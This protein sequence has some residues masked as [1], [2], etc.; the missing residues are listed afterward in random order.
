VKLADPEKPD[1]DIS[2]YV[3]RGCGVGAAG[4]M[5]EHFNAN[6]FEENLLRGVCKLGPLA[7]QQPASTG[8]N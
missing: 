7:P 4:D 8:R 6:V 1:M 3:H 2:T 5:P